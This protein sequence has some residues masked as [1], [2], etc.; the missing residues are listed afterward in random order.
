VNA[1]G[2]I[3]VATAITAR[4]GI[5]AGPGHLLGSALPDLAAMG[6]FRLL[7]RAQSAGLAAGIRLHHRTD[8]EFHRHPWFRRRNRQLT[9]ELTGA[10]LGR[11]PAMACSHVGIELL[12]DG[13]LLAHQP[14]D[15]ARARA[16]AE[17]AEHQSELV[18]LVKPVD[19]A[20][21]MGH[22]EAVASRGLPTD[23]DDPDAVAERLHRIL[24]ARPRLAMARQHVPP[25]AAA[26]A[27]YKP[28]IDATARALVDSV[29][30][31]V[32]R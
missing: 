15:D 10:G 1:G 3:A 32:T 19:R 8:D 23:Y 9:A 14:V 16:L 6:R 11:G 17:I 5:D 24:A 13:Q 18:Q 29:A 25:V 21:W 30:E 2:H 12:L 26:L 7:G 27:R 4:S 31:L 22:L 20:R 28:G